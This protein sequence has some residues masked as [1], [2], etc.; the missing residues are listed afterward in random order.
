MNQPLFRVVPLARRS[1]LQRLLKQQPQENALIELNNLLASGPIQNLSKKDVSEI[2][3]KYSLDL[4]LEFPLNLE[5]FYATYLNYCLSD[6][7][8][9]DAEQATLQ[10]LKTIL[11]LNDRTID[12][13]HVRI[14]AVIYKRS[15]EEALADGRLTGSEKAFLDKLQTDIR[16][17]KE[18]AAKISLE[19]RTAYVNRYISQVLAGQQFSPLQ[20]EELAAVTNSLN[21]APELSD[22]TKQ[23]LERYKHYWAIK[24]LPLAILETDVNLQKNESCHFMAQRVKWFELRKVRQRGYSHDELTLIDSGALLLTNKRII[25]ITDKKTS[26]IQLSK[27]LKITAHTDGIHLAK[28]SGKD[29]TLLL[30]DHADIL[31]LMLERL[32]KE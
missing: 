2:E 6:R 21:I 20:V 18:L 17:P 28:D 13:L 25:F 30:S 12:S 3:K 22:K 14:G 29:V 26:T 19:T 15:F 31:H 27:I 8:L 4:R 32:L 23:Q 7:S 1:F 11:S 10:H 24:N 16:L 5:E 9:S